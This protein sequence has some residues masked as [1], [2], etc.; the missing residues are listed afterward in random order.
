MPNLQQDRERLAI[1]DSQMVE[2]T[3]QIADQ[4]GL[5]DRMVAQGSDTTQAKA[6]LGIMEETLRLIRTNRQDILAAIARATPAG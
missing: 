5:I 1:V 2:S 4:S 3:R 6:L